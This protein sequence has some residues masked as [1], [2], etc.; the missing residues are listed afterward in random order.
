M[1]RNRIELSKEQQA[2]YNEL[3]T[4]AKRAN[5]RIVRLERLQGTGDILSIR[6]LRNKLAS[7]NLQAWTSSGRIKASKSMSE[8]QMKGA[9]K[10][11][12][13]FLANPY[14]TKSG[15]K[16]A[17]AKAKATLK[18]RFGAMTEEEFTDAEAEALTDFFE[19]RDVNRITNYLQGSDV[20][21]I[22][23]DM[24]E[25]PDATFDDFVGEMYRY[26]KYNQG[27]TIP[28]LRTIWT[29]YIRNIKG[30]REEKTR[31]IFEYLEKW[32]EDAEPEEF[33]DIEDYIIELYDDK[34]LNDKE[35]LYYIGLLQSRSK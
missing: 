14:T 20:L 21:A 27:K 12:K 31:Q 16:K 7:T 23:E 15:A 6:Q 29:K 35:M 18:A 3:K 5:Q 13:T 17:K 24:R 9:I 1:S 8:I 4:L 22:I 33:Q 30:S 34:L 32:I 19:D 26:Q 28:Y 10:A 25:K 11:A 2:L